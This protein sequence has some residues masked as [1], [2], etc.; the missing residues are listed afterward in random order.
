M[1]KIIL[2]TSNR[3]K[4]SEFRQLLAGR[5][6]IVSQADYGLQ[7]A[8]ETGLSFVENALLKARY[9]SQKT[10]LPAIADDSSLAV[11]A[12]GGEPG[13]YSAR[14]AGIDCGDADNIKHLLKRM[15]HL[16]SQ[17]RQAKFCC[18]IVMVSHEKDPMPMIAQ[19][20]WHGQISMEPMGDGGFGYDSVFY[21]PSKKLTAAQLSSEE[22]NKASH[23]GQAIAAL[24]SAIQS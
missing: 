21:L 20:Q 24:L 10:G 17:K 12:L 5:F 23:R 2:A 3:G 4:L 8:P 7:S 11:D 9:A 19:G 15:Q 16:P 1:Q 22:K 6:D 18:V 14:Y 13:I